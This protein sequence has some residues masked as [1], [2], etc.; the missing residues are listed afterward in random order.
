MT[1]V[2]I[3]Q[4]APGL[5]RGLRVYSRGM[6]SEATRAQAAATASGLKAWHELVRTRNALGLS[7]VLADDVVFR[8]PIVHTPQEG[9]ARTTMYLTGALHV[10]GNADFTYVREVVDGQNAVLE[11]TTTID[12][13]EVNGVDMITFNDAGQIVDFKVMLRPMKGIQIVG[14]KMVQMLE[15]LKSGPASS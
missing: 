15:A 7:D 2:C 6:T 1:G 9:K 13:I 10:L 11:F 8:S 14:Q 3:Y 4:A 12:G 5:V